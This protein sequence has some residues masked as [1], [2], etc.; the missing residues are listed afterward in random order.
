MRAVSDRRAGYSGSVP[1]L[2]S[3]SAVRRHASRVLFGATLDDKLAPWGDVDP[4]DAGPP[5]DPPDAPGRPVSL[6]LPSG[7]RDVAPIRASDVDSNDG[8]ARVLHEL[9]N[10][11][12]MA[13]EL[14]ALALVRWP[15]APAP[16]RRGVVRALGDEQRHLAAY[17]DRLVAC[18]GEVGEHPVSR[19]FWDTLSRVPTLDAFIAGMSLCF[20]TANLDFAGQWRDRFAAAG[21]PDT[22]RVLDDVLRDEIRHV[23]LGVSWFRRQHDAGW[24]DAW[25]RA[26]PPTLS[27]SRS[28]GPVFDADARR[29]AGFRPEDLDAARVIG[30]SRGRP[31]RVVWF[32]AG[33]EDVIGRGSRSRASL[34]ANRD[35]ASL[36]MF[37][38]AA[39]DVVVA[40]TPDP[41]FL[42]RLADVGFDVP[43]FVDAP[44][45]DAIGPFPVAR[46][47]PWGPCPQP[48]HDASDLDAR[49]RPPR[50]RPKFAV[51]SSKVESA[52][53]AA[54]FAGSPGVV[55][56][57]GAVWSDVGDPGPEWV[58][59]AAFSTSG[60]ERIVGS[61]PFTDAHRGWLA[62]QLERGPVL[63]QPRYDVVA[64]VSVHVTVDADVRVDGITRFAT[65]GVG[66]FAG[67][68]L[69]RWTRGL[70]GDVER[71]VHG[72][73]D[74][75]RAMG[76]TLERAGRSAGEWAKSLG[77]RGPL[78]IDAVVVREGGGYRLHPWLETNARRTLGRV[79]MSLAARIHPRAS[80]WWRVERHTPALAERLA[81]SLDAP[82]V[83]VD[84]R[85]A[86]GPLP[87]T[88]PRRAASLLTWIEVDHFT[89]SVPVRL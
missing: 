37:V 28:R 78:S 9:L 8:R 11:E 27:P 82:P 20:E 13:L 19:H 30:G 36:A 18:G 14:M 71:A 56:E 2:P 15:D 53:R 72:D 29:R 42:A 34:A 4:D 63:W 67:T 66:R 60:T 48:L 21:D 81:Q 22:A 59:K 38:V 57:L 58:V 12:L 86:G 75:A 44:T 54:A 16:W 55:S 41:S 88:D 6:A 77:F 70:P 24:L 1:S 51:L 40:P 47:E 52:R 26:L 65:V 33:I 5:L 84:G 85:L 73:G 64:D 61:G 68:W 32:D 25:A 87:T 50:W 10:H 7:R 76:P 35:L 43:R 3:E 45:A 62:R 69:G 46:I 17:R 31:P 23:A 74:P 49:E 83:R 89:H 79:A 80:A 39:E